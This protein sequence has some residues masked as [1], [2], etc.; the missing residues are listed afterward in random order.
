MKTL[1]TSTRDQRDTRGEFQEKERG[2]KATEKK[3]GVAKREG[4]RAKK[5]SRVG[6]EALARELVDKKGF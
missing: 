2:E 1:S 4:F 5:T 6:A 3:K